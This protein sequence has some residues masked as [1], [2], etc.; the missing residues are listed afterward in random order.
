MRFE[1]MAFGEYLLIE[2]ISVG[3]MAELWRARDPSGGWVAI[4]RM[5]PNLAEEPGFVAMFR[6]EARI[7]RQLVHPNIVRL[8][9]CGTVGKS[10]YI[11]MEYVAGQNLRALLTR[12]Q[13]AGGLGVPLACYVA[14]E[15]CAGLAHAHARRIVHLDLSPENL[16]VGYQGEVKILDFGVA[17][18]GGGQSEQGGLG[19]SLGAGDQRPGKSAYMSP[20]QLHGRVVDHRS[21]LFAMGICL[22]ELLTGHR[23]F[24][25][26]RATDGNEIAPPSLK[27]PDVSSPLDRVVLRALAEEP[28]DRYGTAVELGEALQPFAAT[29]GSLR[30]EL[31]RYVQKLFGGEMADG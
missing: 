17:L 25:A 22:H 29:E 18:A 11:A 30:E 24:K 7:L 16:I 26:S 1:P 14:S 19:G 27:T 12:G 6:A 28:G 10:E 13:R 3:G 21:D 23:L 15:I 20:E 2:R 9:G 4:K 5:L 8:L 31:S